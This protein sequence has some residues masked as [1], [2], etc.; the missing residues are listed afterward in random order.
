M[1]FETIML[2][3]IYE[4]E[5]HLLKMNFSAL[6]LGSKAGNCPNLDFNSSVKLFIPHIPD[7]LNWG[8]NCFILEKSKE[9]G[10]S[11]C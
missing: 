10:D 9:M 11:S 5:T 8:S 3:K 4:E 6:A 7:S 2:N 1:S